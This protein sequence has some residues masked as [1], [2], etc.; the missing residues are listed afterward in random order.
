MCMSE[1]KFVCVFAGSITTVQYL[2]FVSSTLLNVRSNYFA[3]A[4]SPTM[5]SSFTDIHNV[6]SVQ[7][8]IAGVC[9]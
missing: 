3:V 9:V 6:M 5:Q 2:T 4:L 7:Q 8:Q 1:H